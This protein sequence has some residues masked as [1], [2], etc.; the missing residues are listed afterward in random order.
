[1]SASWPLLAPGGHPAAGQEVWLG[2]PGKERGWL[3]TGPFV[4]TSAPS[5]GAQSRFQCRS[6]AWGGGPG[7][8][9]MEAVRSLAGICPTLGQLCA[10]L[11]I[12]LPERMCPQG[13]QYHQGPC[14][15]PAPKNEATRKKKE[16]AMVFRPCI[17]S[18]AW[19]QTRH[20]TLGEAGP[21][22]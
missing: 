14:P 6:G 4:F 19:S 9:R 13:Q 11:G 18:V 16:S 8:L 15:G 12:F 5:R 3:H 7:K 2:V 21:G 20:G 17:L 22:S 10:S 1:M